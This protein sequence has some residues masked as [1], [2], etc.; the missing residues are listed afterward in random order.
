VAGVTMWIRGGDTLCAEAAAFLKREGYAA[1]RVVDVAVTPMSADDVLVLDKVLGAR[2]WRPDQAPPAGTSAFAW[3]QADGG[4][5]RL[6][7]VLT[8]KGAVSGFR[9]RAW[10]DFFDIGKS[11]M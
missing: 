4:R 9:E 11:R 2:L 1:N 6:P 7:I 3:L 5:L 10:M 8:P